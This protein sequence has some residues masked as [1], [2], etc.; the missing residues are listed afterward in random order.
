MIAQ[1]LFLLAFIS[2]VTLFY[3]NFKKILRNIQ[4]GKSISR[5][6]NKKLR[7]LMVLKVAFGQSKLAAKPIAALMHFFIY[8]GFIIINI[9]VLEIIIDGLLGTHRIFLFLGGFYN[10]LI[11]SFEFLALLVLFAVFVFLA[12]RLVLKLKRFSGAEM[13]AW[14]KKDATI[15]LLTEVVLMFAFLIMNASDH[16]LQKL[17]QAHYPI[18]GWF[19]VSQYLQVVLPT[20]AQALVFL[21]RFCWWL[22]IMGIFAFLN[23][24]PYSKHLHII[25]AFPTTWYARLNNLATLDNMATVTNEVKAMLDTSLV[26]PTASENATFGANDVHALHQIQLLNAYTCTECGRCTEVC[27][28]NITGKLLSPRKIMMDTRDRLVEVGQNIDRNGNDYVDGKSL[29]GNYISYEEI[30]ACTSCNA[31]VQAC[32]IN[33]DPL[34]III[35]LRRYAVMEQSQAPN[36]LNNMFANIENN[37]APW[38]YAAAD[39]LNWANNLSN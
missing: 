19:P 10:F 22:H 24:L 39:R 32:P 38:K 14:P 13:T 28:A 37:G 12:R 36:S 11:G 6:D 30:W 25:L 4:L 8:A 5:N 17:G 34:S 7:W 33:I 26:P 23:Y 31:C 16:Q 9:E 2:A 27:P 3:K 20:S 18:A 35:D 1:I 29:L 15:I 21:E